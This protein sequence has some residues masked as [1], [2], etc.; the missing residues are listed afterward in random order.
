MQSEDSRDKP[1]G[2]SPGDSLR[3]ELKAL[4]ICLLAGVLVLPVPIYL[5]GS[6]LFGAD[7]PGPSVFGFYGRFLLDLVRLDGIVWLLACMPY[8]GFIWLR[9]LAWLWRSP[10]S[11]KDTTVS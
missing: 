11:T 5:V 10:R 6:W 4:G 8:L 9:I 1:T 7:D 2:R 3:R